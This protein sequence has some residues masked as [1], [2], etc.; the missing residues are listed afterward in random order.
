MRRIGLVGP[1]ILGRTLALSLPAETHPLGPVLSQSRVSSRRAVR[2]M[3][4]GVAVES[5]SD[6]ENVTTILVAV[7]QPALADELALACEL[8]PN[9]SG[10]RL[11]L[12]GIPT[13]RVFPAIGRL[14][15]AGAHVG[16]LLPMA[17][18][19]RPSV[20]ARDTSFAIW[21]S[22]PALRAARELVAALGG[23]YSAI[24]PHAAGEA[25]LAVTMVSGALST[26]LE[27]GIRRL[28]RAGFSRRHALEALAPLSQSSI[29][30]HRHSRR[31]APPRRLNATCSDLLAA[32]ERGDPAES[33]VCEAALRLACEDLS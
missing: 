17:L 7:P 1:G 16:G 9:P 28:V 15:A 27:L 6:I 14:E 12:T 24:D 23:R 30:E 32:S 31:H 3:K 19:R 21:G 25:L 33:I 4:R 22:G 13:C 18:Y 26:S 29:D 20:V 10:A 5:W 11:L 2:E 8:L